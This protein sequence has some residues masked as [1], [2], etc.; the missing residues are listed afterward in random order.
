MAG[1]LATAVLS[2]FEHSRS[3]RPSAL[4]DVYLGLSILLDIA[5]DR[6]LWLS[7]SSE[8][9]TT[10]T[11]V[12]T[13]ALA[14]K[15]VLII[16]ESRAKSRW[17]VGHDQTKQ[18]LDGTRGI[19]S[20]STFTWLTGLF[21]SGRK[22][23]LRLDD[24]PV[25]DEDMAVEALQAKFAKH[26]KRHLGDQAKR[27]ANKRNKFGL[28][29][30][31]GDTLLVPLLLP[32]LPRI[33]LVGFTLSQ[34]FLIQSV[35]DFLRAESASRQAGYGLIAAAI[36]TYTGIA[37][38]TS[39]YW[40]YHGRALY[41]AR[42]CLCSSVFLK[43]T[44]LSVAT[45][46]KSQAV[47]LMSTD[48][49]RILAGLVNLHE[50]WAGL[51][52]AALGSWLLYNYLGPSLA[53]PIAL[54]VASFFAVAT[55]GRHVGRY[56]KAWMRETQRRVAMT[57]NVIANMKHLKISGLAAAVEESMQR[58]RITELRASRG[59]RRI[60][61]AAM[62]ISLSPE[63]IAPAITLAAT[64]R[65]L[66]AST[67]FTAIALLSLLTAPLGDVFKSVA[68]LM[69]ALACLDRIQ[70]YLELQQQADFRELEG[71]KMGPPGLDMTTGTQDKARD[72]AL[73]VVGGSFGWQKGKPYCLQG[74]D[75]A[76]EYSA[77]TI[78]VGPVGSGKSTL[79]KA[80]L[81][82]TP[83]SAGHVLVSGE[84]GVR[85]A[86]CDQ[87]PFLSNSTIRDNIVGFSAWDS[88]RYAEAVESSGLSRDLA[89]LLDGDGTLVGSNGVIL[90]GGQR[91]RIAIARAL[92][93][94]A[95]ILIFDDVL[96]GLDAKTEEHVF[97]HVFGPDGLLK[98][99][100]GGPAVILCT[101]SVIHLPS[102]D[103][104]VALGEQGD[105]VEQG[106]WDVLARNKGY[107]Q[108]LGVREAAAE[109]GGK[110]LGDKDGTA[111]PPTRLV[112][113]G[114]KG[115]S[116]A[117]VPGAVDG[118]DGVGRMAG[119]LTVYRHY[120]KAVSAV[121][122]TAFIASAVTYGFFFAFPTVWLG[123]WLK[124]AA[125]PHPSQSKAFWIGI[126]GLFQAL[127]LAGVF[128]TM[129][130]AVT[131]VSLVSG[132]ALHLS[133]LRAV[134]RAPLSL[135]TTA[136][137]GTLTN[138]FSQDMTLVDGELPVSLI[139]FSTDLAVSI[140]MAGV[141]AS[142]SPY[143]ATAYPVVMVLLYTV[144]KFYLRTSRQLR[145]LELEAKSPL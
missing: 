122:L 14:T 132:A 12:F 113:G 27:E 31:L 140:S 112:V 54:V 26:A 116:A 43:T 83:V 10:F 74:I 117:A 13:A 93:L 11:G 36:L 96:S 86:Y 81:G 103:H 34:A 131:Y 49:D 115:R 57:A 32:I 33:A 39:L 134:V 22:N 90:S 38:S 44:E 125:S 47:T 91:Q 85:I 35:L 80:L 52:Q 73:R 79:C 142:S 109:D 130:L 30:A 25:L 124:D 75:L 8:L 110:Y 98:T 118:L 15:A 66:D 46:G 135:F 84:A 77:L 114:R 67:L 29:R 1:A 19:Y 97:R 138:Y 128:L 42:G 60:Q 16:L 48:V 94:D 65:D 3:Q 107:V 41:M 61:I 137:L 108:S 101:H 126:Y 18:S 99:R 2:H 139:N 63:L 105:V 51:I 17:I 55:L 62:S 45:V 23:V 100:R 69:S 127:S 120:F 143:L 129:Y 37:T 102:A 58:A 50:F 145:L 82:E 111:V 87:T 106:S 4:L 40:Y 71:E 28:L 119:D 72:A 21:L 5:H 95:R 144:S 68:P 89:E 6:T 9:D 78:I 76:V 53:V 92:Y 20:L 7:A 136:D 56:Q 123:F 24:L 70:T 104:I 59:L 121:A 133:A 141:L 88:D 64:P